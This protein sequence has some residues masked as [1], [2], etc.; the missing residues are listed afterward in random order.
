MGGQTSGDN[1]NIG[2]CS[3]S[4]DQLIKAIDGLASAV[5]SLKVAQSSKSLTADIQDTRAG[6]DLVSTVTV[7]VLDCGQLAT[8]NG[9]HGISAGFCPA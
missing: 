9:C 7:T 8:A 6:G 4:N 3:N 5:E 2:D 1:Q